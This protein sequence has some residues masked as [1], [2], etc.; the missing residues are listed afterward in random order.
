MKHLEQDPDVVY[1]SPDRAVTAS[2]D[3]TQPTVGAN[4]ALQAGFDG[5]GVTIALIDSGLQGRP[6]LNYPVTPTNK[7]PASRIL[8]SE[9]EIGGLLPGDDYGHGTHVSGVLAGNGYQSSGTGALRTFRGIAPNANLVSFRVLD[10]NGNGTDSYVIKAIQNAIN[11]KSKYNIK[12]MNISLGR[13]VFESYTLDPLC[14]AVEQAWR[15]GITVVV[16]AGNSG[17]DNSAGTN[18][19][20]TITA[21]G[22]DPFVITVGGM[23]TMGTASRTDD[24]VA[25]YSSKGPSLV[26]HIVKPDLV[27]PGNRVI[28][29]IQAGSTT[30]K[31]SS[32]GI[33]LIPCTYYSTS[34][35]PCASGNSAM[36]YKLSGTSMA[37]PVVSG[38]AAL[39]LQKDPTL[40]PDQ[41]ASDENGIQE[42]PGPEYRDRSRN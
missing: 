22:N 33:N 10:A 14:Q 27:A 38:A 25:S 32:A 16:A 24:L 21:P 28:S 12:V 41:G 18:G 35:G 2:L 20:S 5:S 7:L 19:Y 36:Y 26:D 31:N 42:F 4:L 37:T 13:P 8:Y 15:A 6:D 23:K 3:Y 17:R 30:Y 11:L 29:L 9:S 1:I 39:M 34:S 40:T